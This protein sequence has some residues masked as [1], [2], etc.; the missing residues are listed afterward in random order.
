MALAGVQIR[1]P[2]V[3]TFSYGVLGQLHAQL[4]HDVGKSKWCV[5][6]FKNAKEFT[7]TMS[8]NKKS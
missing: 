1:I 6:Q 8:I 4:R 2:K 7:F 3:Y 5:L